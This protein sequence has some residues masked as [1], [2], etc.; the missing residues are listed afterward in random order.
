MKERPGQEGEVG[1]VGSGFDFLIILEEKTLSL[2]F[3]LH[4]VI[5]PLLSSGAFNGSNMFF[6]YDPA[7]IKGICHSC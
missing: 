3:K 4:A 7:S 1:L 2:T 5:D 6:F